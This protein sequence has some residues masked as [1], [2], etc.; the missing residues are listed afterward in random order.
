MRSASATHQCLATLN[1]KKLDI[2]PILRQSAI[3]SGWKQNISRRNH[4]PKIIRAVQSVAL[5]F[6]W[7]H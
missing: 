3:S 1:G 5:N 7:T 4:S 2:G 6:T